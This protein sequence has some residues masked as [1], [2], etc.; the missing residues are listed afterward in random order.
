MSVAILMTASIASAA[1]V[2]LDSLL[3]EMT[4]FSAVACWPSPG[5]TLHQCSSYDRAETAPDKPGWFANNDFSEYLREEKHAGRIEKVMMDTD[6]PGCLVRFWLTTVKNK[7]GTLRIYLDG[8][9]EPV[10]SFPAYDLLAGDLKLSAP[11]DQPHPGYQPADNG[12]N[13]LRLPIPYAKHCKITWEEAGEGPRYY[14]INYRTYVAGTAVE[15]FSSDVLAHA[16]TLIEAT[17]K[18][19][20]SPPDDLTGQV[21]SLNKIIPAG[22][23]VTLNLP[24]GPAALRLLELKINPDGSALTDQRL[25]SVI[26]QTQFDGE[27][28]VWC[29][30]TDFFGSGAGIN[31]LQ[32]WYRTMN[33]DGRMSCRWVMPYAKSARITIFNLGDQPVNVALKTHTD[34][35]Q[36]NDRSLHFHAVWHYDENLLTPPV[37]D[38]NAIHIA[39][40]GIYV[41]DTLSLFNY[42]PTWYGEGDEKIWIDD[43]KFPSF[44]GTGMEDY[45]DFSFA[46]RGLMQ[47][48]FANQ[49]RVDQPMTQGHN[50]LTRTRNLDGIPFSRSL[51][52]NFELMSWQPTKLNYAMT[53]YWYALPG[54]TS[55]V[56]P[57][58][59]AAKLPVPTLADARKQK[60]LEK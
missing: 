7:K 59:E 2:T 8:S 17:G 21:S 18:N 20:L 39:G 31:P 37:R 50:V 13:T 3:R 56:H 4:D 14:Q 34:N 40:R 33:V 6:G 15:T 30:M 16:R 26:L 52:F 44:L 43:E 36:W 29:P 49:I 9:D 48:P 11:L 27:E 46:P 28:T 12:G 32:S 60:S 45:Y 53:T 5:F 57:Q 25:R 58:P 19:L 10:I 38:W 1:D 55:N 23:K 24:S 35:W 22:G 42:V 51:D 54:A 41:G 47:T